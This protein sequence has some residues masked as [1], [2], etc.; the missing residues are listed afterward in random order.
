MQRLYFLAAIGCLSLAM[1]VPSAMAHHSIAGQFDTT[2]TLH[3]TGVVSRV[4]W[5]NPHS[6]VYLDVTDAAG[7]VTTWKLESLPVAMMRKAGIT[8]TSLMG[9]GTKVQADIHPARDGSPRWGFLLRL[10]FPDGRYFQF[11][12]DPNDKNG[13]TVGAAK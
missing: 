9:A 2:H 8:K 5:V 1:F 3:L 12:R 11:S 10:T 4:D 7:A 6:A 13:A